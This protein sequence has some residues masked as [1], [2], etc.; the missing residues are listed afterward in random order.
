M[1][2]I[3]PNCCLTAVCVVSVQLWPWHE[4]ADPLFPP[5]ILMADSASLI[6]QA[7]SAQ[8]Q[9]TASQSRRITSTIATK[10]LEH[11]QA[12][13]H[14]A[15]L[16]GILGNTGRACSCMWGTVRGIT[17]R[18]G[19]RLYLHTSPPTASANLQT[20]IIHLLVNHSVSDSINVAFYSIVL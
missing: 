15:T 1:D 5:S 10:T 8:R 18:R 2:F 16:D 7:H 4:D 6:W 3:L 9:G 14:A 17:F 13:D 11:D 20:S 12:S 19:N